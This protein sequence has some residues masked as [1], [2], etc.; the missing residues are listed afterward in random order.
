MSYKT[1]VSD[2]NPPIRGADLWH[3]IYWIPA[4]QIIESRGLEVCLVNA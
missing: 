1:R 3:F 4:Q 2:Y